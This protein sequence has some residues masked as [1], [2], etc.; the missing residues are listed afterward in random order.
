M[1]WVWLTGLPL[2]D[3]TETSPVGFAQGVNRSGTVTP[4]GTAEQLSV[5]TVRVGSQAA[6]RLECSVTTAVRKV[7]RPGVASRATCV[8]REER[9]PI[10]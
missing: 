3:R 9:V 1:T 5:F 8:S 10:P 2:V 4:V 6:D 7:L